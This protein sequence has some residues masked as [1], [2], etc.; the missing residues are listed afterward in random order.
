MGEP[1]GQCL[2]VGDHV[3]VGTDNLGRDILSRVIFGARVPM[4]VGLTATT[5]SVFLSVVIGML[6]CRAL[7]DE[8]EKRRRAKS[9]S[10]EVLTKV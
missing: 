6:R 9:D 7:W 5:L 1:T 8:S 2:F 4:I 3:K 10:S